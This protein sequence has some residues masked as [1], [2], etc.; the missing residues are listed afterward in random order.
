MTSGGE[1]ILQGQSESQRLA[2]QVEEQRVRLSEVEEQGAETT[3]R[4]TAAFEKVT[5]LEAQLKQAAQ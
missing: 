3:D 1:R 2:E 5:Q 4:R